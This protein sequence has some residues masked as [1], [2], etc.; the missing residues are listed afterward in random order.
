MAKRLIFSGPATVVEGIADATKAAQA[1]VGAY[2]YA[3]PQASEIRVKEIYA[4]HGLMI[5]Y[6]QAAQENQR[7]LSCNTV[8]LEE[9]A[10]DFFTDSGN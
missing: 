4:K 7:C 2:T 8:C 6:V 10:F 1:I 9:F 3:I 5:P